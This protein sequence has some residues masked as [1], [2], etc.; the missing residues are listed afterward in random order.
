M[1]NLEQIKEATPEALDSENVMIMAGELDKLQELQSVISTPS[2]Q[3]LVKQLRD[4]CSNMIRD[5]IRD[6]K[7]PLVFRLEAHLNLLTTLVSADIRAEELQ[8]ALDA[9]IKAIIT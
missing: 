4:D 2:G 3:E 5:I 7:N 8:E 9:E 6:V 1:S